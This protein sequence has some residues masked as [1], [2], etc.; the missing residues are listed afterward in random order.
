VVL[1]PIVVIA[2]T[3][4]NMGCCSL[5]IIGKDKI[6]D[7]VKEYLIIVCYKTLACAHPRVC[8]FYCKTEG[9]TEV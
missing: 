4:H 5:G 1:F 2:L 8:V 7:F 3:P 9:G 6:L